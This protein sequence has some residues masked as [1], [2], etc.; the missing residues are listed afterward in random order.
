MSILSSTN[1]GKIALLFPETKAELRQMIDNEIMKKGWN[2]NLNHIKTHK[3][4]EM[5]CLFM[6]SFFNGDISEWDV[7]NV[8]DMKYMFQASDF[9]QDLSK[10]RINPECNT[11]S[12]FENCKIRDE[13]LPKINK[14]T[15]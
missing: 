3:I 1:T 12:M 11:Y 2:C 10:W 8:K 4:T 15:I 13:Y 14:I 6:Y 9:N 7:S 5:T